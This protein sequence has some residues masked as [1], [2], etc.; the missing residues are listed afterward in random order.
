MEQKL[1][2][3]ARKHEYNQTRRQYYALDKKRQIVA[4]KQ[5]KSPQL[6]QRFRS[7]CG[8]SGQSRAKILL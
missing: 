1:L 7:T 8:G 6:S 5:R 4:G 2:S 3:K